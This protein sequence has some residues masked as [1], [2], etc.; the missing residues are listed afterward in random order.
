VVVLRSAQ[1]KKESYI[2][3]FLIHKEGRFSIQKYYMAL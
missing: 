1:P 2:K 3:D